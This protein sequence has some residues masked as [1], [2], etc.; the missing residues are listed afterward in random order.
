M[1][2]PLYDGRTYLLGR[3][4]QSNMVG[5]G[6]GQNTAGQNDLIEGDYATWG[7]A[8]LLVWDDDDLGVGG[9]RGRGGPRT[10]AT[11]RARRLPLTGTGF[12]QTFQPR[13]PRAVKARD[14]WNRSNSNA[15][16]RRGQSWRVVSEKKGR[17]NARLRRT[18]RSPS[19]VRRGSTYCGVPAYPGTGAS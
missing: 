17:L 10:P 13:L 19:L 6:P 15:R 4:V 5:G 2:L 16:R 8:Q 18:L 9:V 3:H 14:G 12:A 7:R 11:T 1:L